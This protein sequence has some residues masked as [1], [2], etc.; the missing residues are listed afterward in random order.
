MING[1]QVYGRPDTQIT[2]K[3][4]ISRLNGRPEVKE[5][6]QNDNMI[7]LTS[8]VATTYSFIILMS[9]QGFTD[10]PL[11]NYITY[12]HLPPPI[13]FLISS[14]N[15]NNWNNSIVFQIQQYD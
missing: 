7:L 2:F 5:V 9:R 1:V 3:L 10:I 15:K 13:C 8:V 14:V 4:N 12:I 6:L 11:H